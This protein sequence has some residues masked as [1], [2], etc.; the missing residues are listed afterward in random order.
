L[1][2]T[3]PTNQHCSHPQLHRRSINLLIFQSD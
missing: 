3:L 2:N 1:R